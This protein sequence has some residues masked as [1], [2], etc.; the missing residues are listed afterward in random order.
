MCLRQSPSKK[1]YDL[2]WNRMEIVIANLWERS[3]E[4]LNRVAS[5]YKRGFSHRIRVKVPVAIN[6]IIAVGNQATL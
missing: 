5:T 3:A 1:P 4:E 6:E 2:I